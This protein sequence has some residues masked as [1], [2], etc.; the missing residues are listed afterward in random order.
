MINS[1]ELILVHYNA[2]YAHLLGADAHSTSAQCPLGSFIAE[3][4]MSLAANSTIALSSGP[5]VL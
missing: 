1:L 2:V 3:H 5:Y 4:S